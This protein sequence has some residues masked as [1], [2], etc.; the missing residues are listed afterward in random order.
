[1]PQKAC[2]Q[3]QVSPQAQPV[4]PTQGLALAW[5]AR[6]PLRFLLLALALLARWVLLVLQSQPQASARA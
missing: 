4:I 5:L 6:S 2:L 1:M 3:W